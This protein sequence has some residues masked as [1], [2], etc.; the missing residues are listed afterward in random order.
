MAIPGITG[1]RGRKP[2]TRRISGRSI[3]IALDGPEQPYPVYRFSRR[4][5][6]EKPKHNPFDGL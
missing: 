1:V 4:D 3:V 6:V 5:F 2:L